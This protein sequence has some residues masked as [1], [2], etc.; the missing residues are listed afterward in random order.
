M[1]PVLQLLSDRRDESAAAL[2]VA[3]E[4]DDLLNVFVPSCVAIG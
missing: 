1:A 3:E 2:L 4:M